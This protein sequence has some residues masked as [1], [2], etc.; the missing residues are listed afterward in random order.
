MK[1]ALYFLPLALF[2]GLAGY[3]GWGLTRD[4]SKI[5][6][7]LID[8]PIPDFALPELAGSGRPALASAAIKGEVALVN[9]FASWCLPCKVEHP[10]FMR[11][12]REGSVR[13]HGI[14]YKDKAEDS[15]AWLAELGNPYAAIGWDFDGRVSIDWGVYGV[16]ETFVIDRAGT[17][18]FK[19][20]GP[21]TPDVLNRDILPLIERLKRAS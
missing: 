19:H 18:R 5:P 6:S 13:I 4:P 1:R 11:L 21:I 14:S 16:P 15:R 20:V 10:I 7:A 9:V 17:I 3:F 12:A 2:L 8:R